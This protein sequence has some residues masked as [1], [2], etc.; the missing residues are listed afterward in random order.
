MA[1]NYLEKKMD[2]YRRGITQKMSRRSSSRPSGSANTNP[3]PARRIAL[4]VG[5]NA[6]LHSILAALRDNPGHKYA[7][8]RSG[9]TEGSRL[10]QTYGALF[11][12]S[13]LP[14]HR[15]L[16]P[17][18][19]TAAARWGGIDTLITDIDTPLDIPA[20]ADRPLRKIIFTTAHTNPSSPAE[21]RIILQLSDT[22]PAN[23]SSLL[24]FLLSTHSAAVSTITLHP[25]NN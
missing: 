19:E 6:L 11:V 17:L 21:T 16:P 20:S 23:L 9:Y 3:D 5:N 7:F 13:S 22:P 15:S 8:T 10:A 4:L 18:L 12:P 2:D 1:D 24:P 25:R 14:L